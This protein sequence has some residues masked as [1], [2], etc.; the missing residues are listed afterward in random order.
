MKQ[1][2]LLAVSSVANID[3]LPATVALVLSVPNLCIISI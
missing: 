3:S 1:K 2:L